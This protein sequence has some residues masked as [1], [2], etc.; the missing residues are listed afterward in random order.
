VVIILQKNFLENF[1]TM[2]NS[3]PLITYSSWQQNLGP[4]FS[5]SAHSLSCFHAPSSHHLEILKEKF[6][7]S[8]KNS[9]EN[10]MK[11]S[12]II[13]PYRQVIS[14]LFTIL[15]SCTLSLSLYAVIFKN[16]YT[17]LSNRLRDMSPESPLNP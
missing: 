4:L 6:A 15:E 5:L 3:I 10:F 2:I 7:Q 13:P 14:A 8:F 9:N 16:I 1:L 11:F 17:L 12:N